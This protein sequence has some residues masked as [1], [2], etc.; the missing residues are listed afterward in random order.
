MLGLPPLG[1]LRDGGN[2]QIPE[3]ANLMKLH[4]RLNLPLFVV[5]VF[6]TNQGG[7]EHSE[8]KEFGVGLVWDS[9]IK[10]DLP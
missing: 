2:L 3:V 10:N 6:P 9:V 7:P 5:H 8:S 4:L 1:S